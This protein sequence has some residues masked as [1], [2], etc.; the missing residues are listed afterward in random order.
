MIWQ[1]QLRTRAYVG[2]CRVCVFMLTYLP[3]ILGLQSLQDLDLFLGL[4]IDPDD[5]I[6]GRK[7]FQPLNIIF[8]IFSW[9]LVS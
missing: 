3:L 1:Q 4:S 7:S 5:L 9:Q 8:Q 6:S 2:V